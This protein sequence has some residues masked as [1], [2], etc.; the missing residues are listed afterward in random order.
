MINSNDDQLISHKISGH[1]ELILSS[2]LLTWGYFLL[3]PIFETVDE[4]ILFFTHLDVDETVFVSVD[5]TR[6]VRKAM[7]G[8]EKLEKE[9]EG[10]KEQKSVSY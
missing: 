4:L 5:G 8:E 7:H 3:Q 9:E 1:L 2:L 10:E 6:I